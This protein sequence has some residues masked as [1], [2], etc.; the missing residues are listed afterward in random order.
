MEVITV[1]ADIREN[2]GKSANK[3]LRKQGLIPA[4]LYGK[5]GSKNLSLT[6]NAVKGLIYTPD[7]KMAKLEVDGGTVDAIVKSIQ[8][9]PVTDNIEHIDFLQLTQG[10]KVKVDIPVRFKGESPGVK[11][12]GSLIVQRRKVTLLLKPE[13]MVDEIW[14]DIS[15]LGLGQSV[16]VSDLEYDEEKIKVLTPGP[17]PVGLVEIPR[18][19]RSADAEAEEA[20]AAEGGAPADAPAEGGD[21]PAAD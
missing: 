11:E 7:F 4:V 19:L 18:A 10:Q 1:A 16:R 5:D 3:S 6:H 2:T 20:A 9:H 21:A 12:G 14:A 8:F 15:S 13:D 17:I